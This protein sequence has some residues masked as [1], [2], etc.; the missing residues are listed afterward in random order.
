MVS[1]RRCRA[2]SRR[3]AYRSPCRT[4]GRRCATC[5]ASPPCRPAGRDV[6]ARDARGRRR[7][8]AYLDV[9]LVRLVLVAARPLVAVGNGEVEGRAGHVALVLVGNLKARLV[10]VVV[11][12]LAHDAAVRRRVLGHE[13]LAVRVVAAQVV[14]V[15]VRRVQ[16]VRVRRR[17]VALRGGESGPRKRIGTTRTRPRSDDVRCSCHPTSSCTREEGREAQQKVSP[18][19][20]KAHPRRAAQIAKNRQ[21]RSRVDLLGERMLAVV[22]VTLGLVVATLL[23][24]T[25]VERRA[26]QKQGSESGPGTRNDRVEGRRRP[27]GHR[28]GAPQ[29]LLGKPRTASRS[30][31]SRR[32]HCRCGRRRTTSTWRSRCRQCPSR[33]RRRAA[34]RRH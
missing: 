8:R 26:V 25:P 15:A 29:L 34:H 24:G 27:R 17:A 3:G 9:P 11:L 20:E 12:A 32:P 13:D 1:R 6:S 14:D 5:A 22:A 10:N 33:S 4:P 19:L 2:E 21:A 31:R 30:A 18:A 28:P 7:R 16:V 23:G